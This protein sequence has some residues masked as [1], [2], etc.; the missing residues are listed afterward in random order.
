MIHKAL[1]LGDKIEISRS[2][3]NSN[4]AYENQKNICEYHSRYSG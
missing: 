3:F 2:K 1:S 4:E